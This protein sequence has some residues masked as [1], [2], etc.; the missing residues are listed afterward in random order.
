MAMYIAKGNFYVWG[1][2]IETTDGVTANLFN[3]VLDIAFRYDG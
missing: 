1:K 2:Y 3:Q